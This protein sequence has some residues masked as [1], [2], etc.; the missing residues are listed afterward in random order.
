M[1]T[2]S[3]KHSRSI[4]ESGQASGFLAMTA[5]KPG[6]EDALRAVLE[7]WPTAASGP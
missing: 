3:K 5:I 7:G 6:E 4:N 1:K 2:R